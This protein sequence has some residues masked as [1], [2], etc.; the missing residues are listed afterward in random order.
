MKQNNIF[1]HIIDLIPDNFYEGGSDEY[2]MAIA[3]RFARKGDATTF[4]N[5]SVGAI[6]VYEGEHSFDTAGD[7]NNVSNKII[8]GYG[9]H[10][11]HGGPHAEVFAVNN[12]KIFYINNKEK[13]VNSK[14]EKE[15]FRQC[16]IY[17]T[18]EPCAH[19]GKTPAC[20]KLIVDQQF[21]KVIYALNDPNP[22]VSGKGLDEIKAK[23]IELKG[24]A[25][26]D[27]NLLKDANYINR[28]F[29]KWIT[30]KKPWVTLKIAS[31]IDG[32]MTT[33]KEWI[34]NTS[35]RNEVH[36]LRAT[37]SLL[38]TGIGTVLADDPKLTVRL[39]SDEL[40]LDEVKQPQ[41]VILKS[42]RNFTDAQRKNL[43]IFNSSENAKMPLEFIIK[44]AQSIQSDFDFASLEE[45]LNAMQEKD[46]HTVMIEAGPKLSKAFLEADLV[47]EIIHY[48]PL[49][50]EKL[51]FISQADIE[52]A[53]ERVSARYENGDFLVKVGKDA[54]RLDETRVS[55]IKPL[56]KSENNDICIRFLLNK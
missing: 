37:H 1:D 50:E 18:L 41:R 19:E 3:L 2:Y 40:D 22:E 26:L 10:K 33:E 29:L 5:P 4:P 15:F 24:P 12:A 17:V 7:M 27:A 49:S 56:G 31:D 55:V 16:S 20:S 11:E 46:M 25:D 34:T 28:K 47:D 36:R 8:V 23:K 42:T 51:D 53:I 21:K 45:F 54:F 52:S 6:I 39:T 30:S 32:N 14:N 38:V 48:E 44:S 9:Y 43:K 13:L 35:S